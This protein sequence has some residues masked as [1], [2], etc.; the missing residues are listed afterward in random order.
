MADL[1]FLIF[2]YRVRCKT[3][4]TLLKKLRAFTVQILPASNSPAESD[5]R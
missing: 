5:Q 2:L 4:R 3:K 1:F